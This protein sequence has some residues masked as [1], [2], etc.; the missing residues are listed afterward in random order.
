MYDRIENVNDINNYQK[1]KKFR[2]FIA[3]NINKW[4]LNDYKQLDAYNNRH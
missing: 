4:K 3:V 2:N 1:P